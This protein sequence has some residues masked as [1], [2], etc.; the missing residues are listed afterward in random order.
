M[1]TDFAH[2]LLDIFQLNERLKEALLNWLF[3]EKIVG[4]DFSLNDSVVVDGYWHK[5]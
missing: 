3:P 5:H 1:D 4:E 2:I